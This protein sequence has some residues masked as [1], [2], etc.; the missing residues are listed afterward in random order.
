MKIDCQHSVA[1]SGYRASKLLKCL[2]DSDAV[3][4]LEQRIFEAVVSLVE[5][6]YTTFM[7]GMSDGFDLLAASAV[8]RLKQTHQGIELV[9]VIPFHGQSKGYSAQDRALYDMVLARADVTLYLSYKYISPK[10]YLCRND[11]LVL[12]S[13]QLLCYYDGQRGGTMYTYNRAMKFGLEITNLAN[14]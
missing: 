2:S 4:R 1:F 12:N 10:Q 3:Q 5:Q 14:L 7:T 11:F 6:G 13:S 9:A 8:L